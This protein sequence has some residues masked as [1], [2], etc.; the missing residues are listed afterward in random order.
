MEPNVAVGPAIFRLTLKQSYLMSEIPMKTMS[1]KN[2]K[3]RNSDTEDDMI[4]LIY[5]GYDVSFL[6]NYN[7]TEHRSAKTRISYGET[8]T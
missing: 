1:S 3:S 5:G 6:L 7:L 2:K 4:P 8:W